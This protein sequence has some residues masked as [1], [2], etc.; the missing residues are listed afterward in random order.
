MKSY[1]ALVGY[2]QFL[3]ELSK[4]IWIYREKLIYKIQMKLTI[5][6]QFSSAALAFY[7]CCMMSHIH[8][9]KRDT[10]PVHSSVTNSVSRHT[11]PFWFFQRIAELL[12]STF[13]QGR[14]EDAVQNVCVARTDSGERFLENFVLEG[15]FER[16]SKNSISATFIN[17]IRLTQKGPKDGR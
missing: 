10:F 15:N 2:I 1:H 9:G 12:K 13:E 11:Y 3:A 8:G 14:D 17:F 4:K 6:W 7:H 16:M 5:P